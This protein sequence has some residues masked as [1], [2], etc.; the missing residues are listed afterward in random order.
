M[1]G[2]S[3]LELLR[4][5]PEAATVAGFGI[6]V[7]TGNFYNLRITDEDLVYDLATAESQE[8]GGDRQVIDQVIVGAGVS[9]GIGYEPSYGEHDWLQE[10]ALANPVGNVVGT[11]GEGTGTAT[12]TATGVTVSAGTPFAAVEVGQWIR[13]P[14]AAVT[15]NRKLAQVVTV[16]GGGSGYTVASGVYAPETGTTGCLFQ[17]AALQEWIHAQ[18]VHFRA[19][20]S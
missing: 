6:I 12:F 14:N 20:Q 17:G 18:D 7:A 5:K 1:L 2:I 16:V 10:A 11:N 3:D 9:G 19:L 4:V 13:T 15:G 8:L